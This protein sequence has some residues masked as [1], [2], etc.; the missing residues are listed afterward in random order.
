MPSRGRN[1]YSLPITNLEYRSRI[2]VC[3]CFFFMF[4]I[5]K[6]VLIILILFLVDLYSFSNFI[7]LRL[8]F[9]FFTKYFI[10]LSYIKSKLLQ[11]P[12]HTVFFCSLCW[13]LYKNSFWRKK[14]FRLNSIHGRARWYV[15]VRYGYYIL[16]FYVWLARPRTE[17]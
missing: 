11:L 13:T 10:P 6:Q 17:L 5:I 3:E 15:G 12:F 1:F 16:W 14:F 9:F 2:P 8:I 7:I 4:H